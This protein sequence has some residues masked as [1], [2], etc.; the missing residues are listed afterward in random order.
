MRN[1]DPAFVRD[2]SN[3]KIEALIEIMY[4]AATADG[5]LGAAEQKRFTESAERLT[6]RVVAG[7]ELQAL[8]TRAKAD[9]DASD[10]DTRLA[11]VKARLPDMEARKLALA[12]AIQITAADGIV[13]TSERELILHTAAALDIDGNT[14]A[15][16]VRD[17]AKT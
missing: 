9:L 11:A 12:L 6:S 2:L 16:M 13:R 15:D 4:L 10:R 7:P 8:L 3:E 5:E 17:L 14:A 1:T